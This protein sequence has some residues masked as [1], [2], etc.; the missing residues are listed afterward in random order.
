V[1]C[2][3]SGRS[4]DPVLAGDAARD[5]SNRELYRRV[6]TSLTIVYHLATH[7]GTSPSVATIWRIL[8]RRGFV[9]P[10]PHK[11][12]RSSFVRFEA[13]LPNERWQADVTHWKLA[14]MLRPGARPEESLGRT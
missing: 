2:P 7:H 8:S 3:A 5:L 12:P 13:D 6:V 1:W 4:P 14:A 10:Q 11:R 9:T